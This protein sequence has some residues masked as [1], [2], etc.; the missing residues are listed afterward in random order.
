MH[1]VATVASHA[2]GLV[3]TPVPVVTSRVF[4]TR[5]ALIGT[6]I[7]PR[8]RVRP[9]LEHNIGGRTPLA[10]TGPFD[11]VVAR[12]VARLAG[13]GAGIA[14]HTVL[15][16]IQRQDRSIFRF[17]MAFGTDLILFQSGLRTSHLDLIGF[18]QALV[19]RMGCEYRGR[20][21]RQQAFEPDFAHD[22][23]LSYSGNRN[24]AVDGLLRQDP[25]RQVL[26]LLHVFGR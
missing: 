14:S 22:E 18:D 7:F 12:T 1:L 21:Q 19:L 8:S 4:V 10:I 9:F 3:G 26:D 17:I 25:V 23:S 24:W 16:L 5:Q 6:F 11:V 20:E 15:G 13:G 2:I